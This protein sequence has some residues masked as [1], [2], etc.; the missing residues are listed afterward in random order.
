M[1]YSLKDMKLEIASQI[2]AAIA[3]RRATPASWIAT[4]IMARFK[5]PSGWTGEARDFYLLNASENVRREVSQVLGQFKKETDA[6]EFAKQEGFEFVQ[7]AYPIRRDGEFTIVPVD[8]M[9]DDEVEAKVFELERMAASCMAHAEELRR[10][11][12]QRSKA[13]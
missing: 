13:A 7:K 12:K 6:S 4:S 5:M 2:E 3:A 10:F 11:L 1:S 9:T 8:A